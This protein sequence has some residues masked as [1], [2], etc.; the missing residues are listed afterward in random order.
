MG[1]NCLPFPSAGKPLAVR[2]LGWLLVLASLGT[3]LRALFLLGIGLIIASQGRDVLV[4]DGLTLRYALLKVHLENIEEIAN[5][6]EMN[7]G[8]L[9][10]WSTGILL[11]P[12]FLAMSLVVLLSKGVWPAL[13]LPPLAYWG[14]LYVET[15][16]FPLK[17]LRKHP[18]TAVL[19]PILVS[20]PFAM[21]SGTRGIGLM[22]FLWF[23]GTL[24]ILNLL[25]RDGLV[26]KASGKG[27]LLLCE[28]G[29]KLMGVLR[30]VVKEG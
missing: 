21:L 2:A 19:F 3:N 13:V 8:T 25:L 28:D 29:E 23:M 5:L 11:E 6:S 17:S 7:R 10:R 1:L 30:D 16:L 14:T 15:V 22:L 4:D 18:G 12:L 24:S 20:L 26:I 27:Y 9:I